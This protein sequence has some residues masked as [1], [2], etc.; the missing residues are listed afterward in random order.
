MTGRSKELRMLVLLSRSRRNS[1]DFSTS[2]SRETR[3]PV[4]FS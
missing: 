2:T 1:K 4:S 3:L